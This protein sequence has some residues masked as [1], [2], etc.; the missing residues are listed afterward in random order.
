MVEHYV[1]SMVDEFN[2]NMEQNGKMLTGE[3][4]STREET[5]FGA[6]L[7]TLNPTLTGL[8]SNQGLCG[9]GPG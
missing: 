4:R 9:E 3:D 1:L 6:A 5:C 7:S 2:M 8:G